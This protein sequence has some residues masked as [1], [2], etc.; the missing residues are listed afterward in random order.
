MSKYYWDCILNVLN[1]F[2]SM[3]VIG[4]TNSFR[5]KGLCFW[6]KQTGAE[7]RPSVILVRLTTEKSTKKNSAC[8]EGGFCDDNDRYTLLTHMRHMQIKTLTTS[9]LNGKV[10]S[11][12]LSFP[13][14]IQEYYFKMSRHVIN[15]IYM[16]L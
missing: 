1:I 12:L 2:S 16:I 8:G 15:T 3:F 7:S 6:K 9:S 10:F 5:F 4:S 13:Y 11:N 14:I